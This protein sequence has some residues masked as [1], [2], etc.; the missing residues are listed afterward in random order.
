MAVNKKIPIKEK[1][2]TGGSHRIFPPLPSNNNKAVS[3]RP[4]IMDVNV[5]FPIEL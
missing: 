4:K 2:M 1:T 5:F 3:S